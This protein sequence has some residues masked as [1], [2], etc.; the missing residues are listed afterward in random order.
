M[1]SPPPVACVDWERLAL[2]RFS[3]FP[4]G[5]RS[6]KPSR[7]WRDPSCTPRDPKYGE[8]SYDWEVFQT[9]RP[10]P[11]ELR[12]WALNKKTNAAI[13]TG[14]VSGIIVLD[15]D[16]AEAEAEVVKRGVPVTPTVLTAKGRHRYFAYPSIPCGNRAN[17]FKSKPKGADIRG[18]GGYVVA[19]GSVHDTKDHVYVWEVEPVDDY[20][21][22]VAFAPVPQWLIE[23]IE[24]ADEDGDAKKRAPAPAGTGELVAGDLAP[25]IKV[26]VEKALDNELAAVRRAGQGERNN[27]LNVAAYNLGQLIGAGALARGTV[28]GL[29]TATALSIGLN[30]AEIA[31]TIKSGLTDGIA[32]PRDLEKAVKK[33]ERRPGRSSPRPPPQRAMG[34]EGGPGEEPPPHDQ[35]DDGPDDGAPIEPDGGDQVEE[36][37][38][39]GFLGTRD[40]KFFFCTR[41]GEIR[42]VADRGFSRVA[43]LALFDGAREFLVERFPETTRKGA[44][45]GDFDLTAV[46]DFL[47][48]ESCKQPLWDYDTPIRGPGVWRDRKGRLV[49]HFGDR[50]R[51]DGK[52]QPA[53][54]RIDGVIYVAFPALPRPAPLP[55]TTD[56]SSALLEILDTWSWERAGSAELV[57]GWLAVAMLGAAVDWRPH[58]LVSGEPG[59]GKS[60]LASLCAAVLAVAHEVNLSE[61][62]L[63]AAMRSVA[64][65]MVLDEQ[66]ADAV[67]DRQGPLMELIRHISGGQGAGV[68]RYGANGRAQRQHIVAAVIMLAVTPPVLQAQDRTRFTELFLFPLPADADKKR[69][70][71]AIEWAR[72]IS[73]ALQTRALA[74]WARYPETLAIYH[75]AMRAAQCD[76]RA[77]DQLGALLAGRD[78]MLSDRVPTIEEATKIAERFRSWALDATKTEE[79]SNG[80][81]CLRHLLSAPVES[82]RGGDK[83]TVGSLI[84]SIRNDPTSTSEFRRALRKHG[85]RLDAVDDP[86]DGKPRWVMLVANEHQALN[87]MFLGSRWGFG[88]WVSTL[89]QIS[90]VDAWPTSEQFAGPKVRCTKVPEC[91]LPEPEADPDPMRDPMPWGWKPPPK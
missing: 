52:F 49:V 66:E 74:G 65:A 10:T 73:P 31:A 3:I 54:L 67:H 26:Y 28:E 45:T 60:A 8:A 82:W 46:V 12:E 9:R 91:Y 5:V 1:T 23:I 18:D 58:L 80:M 11:K 37:F 76:M 36:P 17:I 15:T 32:K 19:P 24:R 4:L 25:A 81:Q 83:H 41:R 68:L 16:S 50:I 48:I 86:V 43:V 62:G 75:D 88:K 87:K 21:K 85:V 71:A 13:A 72:E 55:A 44:A 61:P 57:L 84:E 56:Q 47:V 39:L 51:Y 7:S 42:E 20:G 64:R 29:L 78:L 70:E 27:T 34:R 33:R 6:K 30:A 35:I 77:A 38:P 2:W 53:G 14:Q 40:G 90:L 89:R 69:T 59:A 22:G 63:R 79:Q